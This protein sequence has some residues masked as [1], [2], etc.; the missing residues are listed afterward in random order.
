M[1]EAAATSTI[2]SPGRIRPC[3]WMAYDTG[4]GPALRG[5][6][7]NPANLV[8]GHAGVMFQFKPSQ[9]AAFITAQASKGHHG[10]DITRPWVNTALPLR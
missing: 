10:A 1:A 2:T 9:L 8:L 5:L 7:R 4:Q 3:R 6:P